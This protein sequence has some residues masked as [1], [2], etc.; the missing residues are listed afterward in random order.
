LFSP[1]YKY[2]D[3]ISLLAPTPCL[4]IFRELTVTS[5]EPAVKSKEATF[6]PDTHFGAVVAAG[7]EEDKLTSKSPLRTV[8]VLVDQVS[9]DPVSVDP[10]SVVVSSQRP[11]AAIVSSHSSVVSS[12]ISSPAASAATLNASPLDAFLFG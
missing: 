8:P 9:V 12:T 5:E 2:T 4:L 11:K 7:V 3:S 10:V 6:T 1:L